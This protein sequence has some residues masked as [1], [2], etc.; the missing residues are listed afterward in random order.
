MK[1]V[2]I[3]CNHAIVFNSCGKCPKSLYTDDGL[4][5]TITRNI[6]YDP[7]F[8]NKSCRLKTFKKQF[9][10]IIDYI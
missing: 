8:I 9:D 7:N 6:I 5:C 3:S 1:K 4:L 2:I 10:L